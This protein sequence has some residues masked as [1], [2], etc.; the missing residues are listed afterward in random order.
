[1]NGETYV[2]TVPRRRQML[3][4]AVS[5]RYYSVVGSLPKPAPASRPTVPKNEA[6]RG[7]R[8]AVSARLGLDEV[9]AAEDSQRASRR[10][11]GPID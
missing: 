8:G 9:V 5:G 1:M 11:A 7:G 6:P 3:R 4:K 10:R 2:Q